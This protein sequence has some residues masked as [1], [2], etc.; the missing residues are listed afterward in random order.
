M[1]VLTAAQA[2][3]WKS[4]CNELMFHVSCLL[5]IILIDYDLPEQMSSPSLSKC[6][7]FAGQMSDGQLSAPANWAIVRWA[8]VR[9][10]IVRLP[11]WWE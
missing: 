1:H 3:N 10:A 7:P 2:T 6:P 9:W 8:I 4:L 11:C 5:W